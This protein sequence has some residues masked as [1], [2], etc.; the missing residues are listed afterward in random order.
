MHDVLRPAVRRFLL[1]AMAAVVLCSCVMAK[2]ALDSQAGVYH[3]VLVWLKQP[4][5]AE[6]IQRIIDASRSFSEIPG[7]L[8]VEAGTSMSSGRDIVDDSF[9]VG[10]IISFP[11]RAAMERYL[12][13]PTHTGVVR[14]V[15]LPLVTKIVVYDFST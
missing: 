8:H 10:I 1:P 5:D 13:H 2:P 14:D 15:L 4:G 6:A 12:S 3:I 11:D 9:D 7:V